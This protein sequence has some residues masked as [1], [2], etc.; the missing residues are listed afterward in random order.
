M[1]SLR[2][3]LALITGG[4]RGLGRNTVIAVAQGGADVIITYRPQKQSA[5]DVVRETERLGRK[6]VAHQ[7]DT[8]DIRASPAF[9]ARP[10]FHRLN[11]WKPSEVS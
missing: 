1:S 6:V 3:K 8:A 7:L 11:R 2:T 5:L 4:S 10:S 9:V